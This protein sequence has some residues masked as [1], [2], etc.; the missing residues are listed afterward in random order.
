MGPLLSLLGRP[1]TVLADM[2]VHPPRTVV[3]DRVGVQSP[4]VLFGQKLGFTGSHAALTPSGD[5][6]PDI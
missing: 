6:G 3:G 5:A 1:N 2:G 4:A